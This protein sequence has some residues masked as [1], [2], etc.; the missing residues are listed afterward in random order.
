MRFENLKNFSSEDLHWMNFALYHANQGLGLTNFNPSVG[1]VIIKNGKLVSYARTSDGGKEHAEEIAINRAGNNLK[2]S[3]LYV[4]LEPC[5]HIRKVGSC[6]IKI[7]NS[8]INRVVIGCYDPDLRTNGQSIKKLRENNID[9]SYGCMEDECFEL[10]NG[11]KSRINNNRPYVTFKIATSLDGKL[12]LSNLKS[13]WITNR[14]TRHF[15][16]LYRARSD[17]IITGVNTIIYDNPL[18]NCRIEGLEKFSP[19]VYILD[20]KLRVPLNSKILKEKN[21]T[22][23]TSSKTEKKL[24]NKLIDKKLNVESVDENKNGKLDLISICRNLSNKK[25]N[26]LL[27][28]A[29]SNL[30]ASFLND[31][32]I[33]KIIL[34]RS[35]KILGSESNSFS[36]N[37]NLT[38]IPSR[39]NFYLQDSFNINSNII[40]HWVKL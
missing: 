9:V 4:T 5:A 17:A 24:I 40:E 23:F 33:D 39:D 13:K 22:I 19:Y 16:H 27:V 1:C 7:L 30:F 3:T 38:K 35:G 31:N 11:F 21:T 28:E 18:L 2:N 6:L 15:I 29:G 8:S 36:G 20:T 26:N 25:I 37:L 34:C 32:L 10:I 12:S 14:E